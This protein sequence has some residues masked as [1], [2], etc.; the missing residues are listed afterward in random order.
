MRFA[1]TMLAAITCMAGCNSKAVPL[2]WVRP[3]SDPSVFNAGFGDDA[4]RNA[5]SRPLANKERCYGYIR[6]LWDEKNLYLRVKCPRYVDINPE[7]LKLILRLKCREGTSRFEVWITHDGKC[8]DPTYSI[9]PRPMAPE[10]AACRTLLNEEF[11]EARIRLP[12]ASIHAF[13]NRLDLTAILSG[14]GTHKRG[15]QSGLPFQFTV[16]V[17]GELYFDYRTVLIPKGFSED[18]ACSNVSMP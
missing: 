14:T 15:P 8:L 16:T 11:W 3:T 4:W 5:Q 13:G 2:L 9:G 12:F 10:R 6:Y 18:Q 7:T 1:L 17:T